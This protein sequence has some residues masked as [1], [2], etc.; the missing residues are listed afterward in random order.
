MVKVP[1]QRYQLECIPCNWAICYLE[2]TLYKTY[3]STVCVNRWYSY[4]KTA[5]SSIARLLITS[6][7]V[8]QILLSSKIVSACKIARAHEF[9]SQFP[10]QYD[11][12][13][14]RIPAL[15]R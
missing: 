5:S 4:L 11:T 2:N 13:G 15:Y 14:L 12:F 7:W 9:V 6:V 8:R 3:L 1:W 10:E